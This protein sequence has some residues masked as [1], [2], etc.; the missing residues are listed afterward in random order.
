MLAV[1]KRIETLVVMCQFV[2]L[3]VFLRKGTYRSL[4]ERCLGMKL[5]TT[6]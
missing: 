1:M 5:V 3:L 6:Q 4:P 2:N